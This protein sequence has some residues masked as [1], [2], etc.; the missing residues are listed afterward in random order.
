MPT[1]ATN[2]RARFDYEILETVEAG[3]VLSGPEVK[4]IRTGSVKLTGSF[5]TFHGN[6]VHLIN[7][8]I[9]RYKP[10]ANIQNYKPD[11]SRKLLLHKKE[12]D[13]LRG[14]IQSG[15]GLTIVPL[16]LYTRGPRIKVE[17]AVVRG[18]KEYDKREKIKKRQTEREMARAK[19][20]SD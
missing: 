12:I 14:T 18:K 15:R 10:A 16:S 2:K 5:V 17:I 9:P 6:D 3:L 11:R 1:Y 4:S 7:L 19:V 8:H 13:R 20:F